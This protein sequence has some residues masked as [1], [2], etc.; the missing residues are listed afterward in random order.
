MGIKNVLLAGEELIV[1]LVGIFVYFRI[2][3]HYFT[4]LFLIMKCYSHIILAVCK[5]GCHL[6]HGKC[7]Y[8]GGC[9]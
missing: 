7:D 4:F 1:K 2:I 8:P 5:T 9:E 3:F 6:E